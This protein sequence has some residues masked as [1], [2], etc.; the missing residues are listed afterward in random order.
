L[1]EID[2]SIALGQ[3]RRLG[4]LVP[5]APEDANLK[6]VRTRASFWRAA[7]FRRFPLGVERGSEWRIDEA[8]NW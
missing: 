7:V 4:I 6:P 8:K 1:I 5:K 2:S 3:R